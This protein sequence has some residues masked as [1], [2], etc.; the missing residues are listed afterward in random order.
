M[1]LEIR[2]VKAAVLG[3][4]IAQIAFEAYAWLVSPLVFGPKLQPAMLVMGLIEKYMGISLSYEVAFGLHAL[5]GVIGFGIFTLFFY[6]AFRSRAILS[7]FI[8]GVILWFIAQGM[9]AP[10][11]GREFMMGF[12]PYTQSS[13][14]AHVGM[15]MIIALFISNALRQKR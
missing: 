12:G 1:K 13:F 7:G 2:E 9:L 5:I 14:V 11:M 8:S 4:L 10:A 15:T 3:G 6:K